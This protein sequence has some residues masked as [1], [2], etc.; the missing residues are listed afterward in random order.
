MPRVMIHCPD[1][2]KPVYTGMNFD[3]F[4]F[5]TTTL[6]TRKLECPA[7]GKT[8]QWTR[9]DVYLDEEGGG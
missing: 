2:G 6:G 5:E 9:A 8:H 3:W 7:C 4:Q 1:T